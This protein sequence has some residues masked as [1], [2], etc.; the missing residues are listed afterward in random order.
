MVAVLQVVS[1]RLQGFEYPSNG[2]CVAFNRKATSQLTPVCVWGT[3]PGLEV[4][5]QTLAVGRRGL[6]PP[7]GTVGVD[8]VVK[9]FVRALAVAPCAIFVPS[10]MK[11]LH[12]STDFTVAL[13]DADIEL[14]LEL[15]AL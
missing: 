9:A 3:Y 4:R 5:L 7:E 13:S 1:Q 11:A 12:K 15:A 8:T 2:C 14:S 6:P 10:D